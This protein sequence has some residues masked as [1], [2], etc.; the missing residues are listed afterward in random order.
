[1]AEIVEDVLAS[2][3]WIQ[4]NASRLNGDPANLH[5]A[6]HSAGGHLA[7][8]AA[9]ARESDP[10]FNSDVLKSVLCV[11]GLFDLE[12]VTQSYLRED[13]SF[14]EATIQDYSPLRRK[15]LKLSPPVTF[16]VGENETS[17]FL[18][19]SLAMH[20]SLKA[21]GNKSVHLVL[22]GLNHFDIVYELGDPRGRIATAA[23][24]KIE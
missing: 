14:D 13:L 6:G 17:E 18:R 11:S 24:E 5:L 7:L 1:M 19:Q 23:L 10:L 20:E 9:I 16:A 2:I 22:P 21:S 8:I 3:L 4:N 12:P 15:D